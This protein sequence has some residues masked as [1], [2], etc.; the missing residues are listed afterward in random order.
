MTAGV[1]ALPDMVKAT[2]LVRVSEYKD[3]DTG[4]D[5]HGEHDFGKCELCLRKFLWGLSHGHRHHGCK[6]LQHSS[7]TFRPPMHPPPS[8]QAPVRRSRSAVQ[9]KEE[10]MTSWSIGEL[11]HLTRGEL[12]AL[13]NK[14]EHEL[15]LFPIRAA[16]PVS[17]GVSNSLLCCLPERSRHLSRVLYGFEG[18]KSSVAQ[19]S[20]P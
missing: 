13:T 2:A 4:N 14:L 7:T 8:K 17:G 6:C 11:M 18:L 1:D 3:F 16:M 15:Q 19:T 12:C 20:R 9:A 5:P 10:G